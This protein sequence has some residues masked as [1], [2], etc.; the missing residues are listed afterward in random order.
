MVFYDYI[1]LDEKFSLI[2]EFASYAG[3]VRNLSFITDRKVIS[4]GD[5]QTIKIWDLEKGIMDG[6]ELLGHTGSII[7]SIYDDSIKK[8]VSSSLD[9]TI[10]VWD[11]ETHEQVFSFKGNSEGFLSKIDTKYNKVAYT[12]FNKVIIKDLVTQDVIGEIG[13]IGDGLMSISLGGKGYMVFLAYKDKINVYNLYSGKLKKT[14][15]YPDDILVKY[16]F[17]SPDDKDLYLVDNDNVYYI[18]VGGF[19]L[20]SLRTP[21]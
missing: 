13:E 5:D 7:N 19:L 8:I 10:R 21:L 11:P 18:N 20:D 3:K 12:D 6:A 9:K 1:V 16:I 2:K 4:S 14:I 17:I 15:N